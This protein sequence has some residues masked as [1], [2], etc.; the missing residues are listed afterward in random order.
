MPAV[1]LGLPVYN[2]EKFLVKALESVLAQTL[3]DFELIVSDN[4]SMDWSRE[5]IRAY[6]MKDSRIRFYR[7]PINI[8]VARNFNFIVR[9]AR[10]PYFKF[11]SA[12]DEY[13]PGLLAECLDV[14]RNDASVVLCFGRTRLIDA[15]GERRDHYEERT[16]ADMED[17]IARYDAVRSRLGLN[18]PIQSGVMRL[19]ALKRCRY[20]GNYPNSDA[21]LTAALAL[22][23]RFVLLPQDHFYRRWSKESASSL[24]SPLEIH[25]LFEPAVRNVSPFVK[26]RGHLG[27][28]R[29]MATAPL[30]WRDRIRGLT[31]VLRYAYWDRSELLAELRDGL[32][33][34][35]PD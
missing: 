4:A 1:S 26:M 31:R 14:L 3:Q 15:S 17:P 18:T 16:I 5:I 22:H 34:P 13:A 29:R 12:N 10:A 11:V 30:S 35:A 27:H 24:R 23:G 28:L 21:V 33:R 19:A 2:G 7:Q 25:R 6:A 9:Q 32:R 8:G 20:L